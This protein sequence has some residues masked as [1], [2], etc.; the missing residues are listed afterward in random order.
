MT[1]SEYSAIHDRETAARS[2]RQTAEEEAKVQ[3]A[4]DLAEAK[5]LLRV[6]ES[7]VRVFRTEPGGRVSITAKDLLALVRR[8]TE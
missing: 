7:E 1:F 4:S 8:I 2:A 3:A 5:T 6:N